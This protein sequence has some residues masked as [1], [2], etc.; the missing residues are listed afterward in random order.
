MIKGTNK[1][2]VN[3]SYKVGVYKAEIFLFFIF[4]PRILKRETISLV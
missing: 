2:T 4:C 3:Y 1:N